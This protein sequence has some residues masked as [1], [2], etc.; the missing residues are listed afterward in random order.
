ML[1]ELGARVVPTCAALD[2]RPDGRS[3]DGPLLVIVERVAHGGVYG[4]AEIAEWVRDARRLA[5]L[6]HPNVARIRDVV[7]DGKDVLVVGEFVDGVRWS[8]VVST[9]RESG[10][11]E[12]AL[13]VLVDVLSGLSA[14][15]NLRD[16]QREP[17]KLVHGE[18]TPECIVLGMDGAARVVSTC[19]L[20]SATARPGR[21]GSA[22]LAPEVLLADEAADARADVYSAGVMLWEALSERALFPNTQPSAIVTQLLSGGVVRATIPVGS[23]WAAPLADVASR[24]LSATPEKRFPSA[25]ALAAELRRIAGPRLATAARV[26]TFVRA[27]FGERVQKRRTELERGEPREREISGVASPSEPASVSVEAPSVVSSAS[28]TPVPAAPR[29]PPPLRQGSP[30]TASKPTTIPVRGPPVPGRP[31]VLPRE[32]LDAPAAG[33]EK[34]ALPRPA[35]RDRSLMDMPT[36]YV[37]F[38]VPSAARIPVD[39]VATAET[40][41][42][43]MPAPVHTAPPVTRALPSTIAPSDPPAAARARRG[44]LVALLVGP[45]VFGIAVAAWW[46]AARSPSRRAMPQTAAV[47][48]SVLAP[49]AEARGDLPAPLPS[50]AGSAALVPTETDPSSEA[51]PAATTSASAALETMESARPARTAPIPYAAPP[52][53]VPPA[54]R[55]PTKRTY[56]PEG[57]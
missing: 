9:P 18:L 28:P 23:A 25:A 15:H 29:E 56:D 12:I 44:F 27:T 10:S 13:R 46:L 32:S 5:A 42:V 48:G 8:E 38:E 39:V 17:L 19:R 51:S 47:R 30:R 24:A 33:P 26:A 45:V 53:Y 57:I 21:D 20:R 7:L 49:P 34:P 40:P 54:R 14:V 43:A 11:L 22:Y 37:A 52:A 35:E 3:D 50:G 31:A 36:P 16:A 55:P 2:A 6:E 4:D 41:A 1:R